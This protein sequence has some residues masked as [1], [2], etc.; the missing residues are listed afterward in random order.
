MTAVCLES[1]R[2][3][4]KQACEEQRII[5]GQKAQLIIKDNGANAENAFNFEHYT[6]GCGC[7]L[8]IQISSHSILSA[9]EPK[10]N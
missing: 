8:Q 2:E 4:A 7:N 9:P 3:Y 10:F 1:M 6:N 5:C